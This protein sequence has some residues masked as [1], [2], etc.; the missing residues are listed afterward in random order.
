M[1]SLEHYEGSNTNTNGKEWSVF[2]TMQK[3]ENL[4]K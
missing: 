4:K 2:M 1:G 3:E